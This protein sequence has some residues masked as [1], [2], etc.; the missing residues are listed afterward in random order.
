[1]MQTLNDFNYKD[2]DNMTVKMVLKPEMQKMLKEIRRANKE[3]GHN[4]FFI[5]KENMGY[6]VLA[7]H[8]NREVVRVLNALRFSRYYSVRI[9]RNLFV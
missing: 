3:A 5:F 6:S 7:H 2:S 9:D 1:M 8:P 4:I